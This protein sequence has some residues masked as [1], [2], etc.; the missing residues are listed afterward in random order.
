MFRRDIER[1]TPAQTRQHAAD[2]PHPQ[3]ISRNVVVGP[4]TDGVAQLVDRVFG[5]SVKLS[6]S[7]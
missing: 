3:P 5:I 2:A 4:H 7:V 1:S 6:S